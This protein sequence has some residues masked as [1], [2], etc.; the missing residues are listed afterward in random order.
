MIGDYIT[1]TGLQIPTVEALLADIA[2]RQKAN[3]SPL[4]NT[5]PDSPLGNINGIFVDALR[6]AWEAVQISYQ[7]TDPDAAEGQQL[8]GDCALTGTVRAAAT[9]SRFAGVEALSVDLNAGITVPVGTAFTTTDGKT[10][11]VVSTAVTSVGSGAYLIEAECTEFGPV[12]CN[13]GTLTVIATV[14]SGMNS[15]TNP[16][17][18]ILG[19]NED[20]DAQLRLR[21]EQELRA[22][23]SSN[24]A[25]IKARLLG[26]TNAVGAKP[27]LEARIAV[28]ESDIAV[29]IIPPHSLE[30]L[31]YDGISPAVANDVIAQII[32]EAKA[33]GIQA[34]G[35]AHGLATDTEGNTHLIQF[36]R[37]TVT[38]FD[39]VMTIKVRAFSYAGDAAVKAAVAA[40]FLS[41]VTQG[42]EIRFVDSIAAV[43]DGA[44]PGVLDVTNIQIGVHGG[45]L[46]APFTNY[47]L[48]AREIGNTQA[49]FVAL[50]VVSV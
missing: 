50:T 3:I 44:V 2:E 6:D 1:A 30:C 11:F 17:D 24:E 38:N 32:W 41:Q 48:G 19:T 16:Y 28:N 15:V 40:R 21:R 7:G 5:D 10:K 18:A 31:V 12:V 49:S 4:L 34:V 22:T 27:I 13:A 37:P 8:D 42:S 45:G 20:T 46:N 39:I 25:A 14:I 9:R 29:G 43:V 23:G 26:Y 35:F 47:V 33:A 36:S